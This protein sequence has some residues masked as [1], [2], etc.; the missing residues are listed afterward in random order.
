MPELVTAAAVAL[1]ADLRSQVVA[2]ERLIRMFSRALIWSL[3]ASPALEAV[4]SPRFFDAD[5]VGTLNRIAA[6][7]SAS[8]YHGLAVI[9]AKAPMI[10][11]VALVLA[12]ILL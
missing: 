10:V 3:L 8:R 11:I 4:A 2:R 7:P 12:A 5:L 6:D 1:P 9:A